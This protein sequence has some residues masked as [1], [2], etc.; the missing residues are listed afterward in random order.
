MLESLDIHLSTDYELRN[1]SKEKAK[2]RF[3]GH[4]NWILHYLGASRIVYDM[5]RGQWTT[6]MSPYSPTAWL[7]LIG[8]VLIATIWFGLKNT[9]SEFRKDI[10]LYQNVHE[11]LDDGRYRFLSYSAAPETV[12]NS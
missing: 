2:R 8:A 3:P 10:P 5:K 6:A 7:L 1:Y 12:D 9:V 4:K 11:K